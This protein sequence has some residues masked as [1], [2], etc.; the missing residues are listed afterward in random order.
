MIDELTDMQ[1]RRFRELNIL[2]MHK[3][4]NTGNLSETYSRLCKM[5]AILCNVP[6]SNEY[7][8]VY[9]LFRECILFAQNMTTQNCILD[10]Q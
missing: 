1:K 5:L 3:R 9:K 7:A 2:E 10:Y 4:L 8:A 6:F